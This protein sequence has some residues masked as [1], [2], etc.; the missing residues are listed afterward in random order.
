MFYGYLEMKKM[1]DYPTYSVKV[2]IQTHYRLTN[3]HDG[4]T[5][6]HIIPS[7]RASKEIDAVKAAIDALRVRYFQLE[8]DDD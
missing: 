7:V 4:L 8:E 3:C 6:D 1:T 2:I 5:E